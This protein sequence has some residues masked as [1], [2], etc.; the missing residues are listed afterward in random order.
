M[1]I[2][3]YSA[4]FRLGVMKSALQTYEKQT[5]R[6]EAGICHLHRPKGYKEEEK[7]L[8][9]EITKVAWSKP[10]DTVIFCP[11]TPR[12]GLANRL[13]KVAEGMTEASNIKVKIVERAGK[14]IKSML[15]GLKEEKK[16]GR[17][18]CIVHVTGGKGNFN[19]EGVVYQ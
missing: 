19:R 11:P 16:C 6:D 18:D 8:K 10:Y 1:K 5:E 3:G 7:K 13:K 17:S 14:S 12:S 2:S 15:P 4:G 9:K